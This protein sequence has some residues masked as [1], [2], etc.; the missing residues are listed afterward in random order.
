MPR[1]ND[2]AFDIEPV[3]SKSQLGSGL[4]AAQ[5][6]EHTAITGALRRVPDSLIAR[7]IAIFGV[8]LIR[9]RFDLLEADHISITLR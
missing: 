3:D 7:K 9:S 8:Q 4:A 6:R 1:A 2:A 5:E